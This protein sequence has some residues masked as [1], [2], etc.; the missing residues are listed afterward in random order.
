MKVL[1]IN[2]EFPDTYW[3]FRRA[4]RFEGQALS[5]SAVG[6]VNCLGLAVAVMGTSAG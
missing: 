6:T 5:F 2:P 1:L 3:S 4:V